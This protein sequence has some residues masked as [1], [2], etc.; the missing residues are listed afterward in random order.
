[1]A[2]RLTVL[3]VL[4]FAVFCALQ[5]QTKAFAVLFATHRFL[6]RALAHG[7]PGRHTLE[8]ARVP[9]VCQLFGLQDLGLV[10][11]LVVAARALAGSSALPAVGKALAVKFQASNFRALAA[12]VPVDLLGLF[13][14]AVLFHF[15]GGFSVGP[16]MFFI[17]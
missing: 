12:M 14:H 8:M 17:E 3:T 9:V 4:A 7:S 10:A 2:V 16:L 1:M 11:G 5:T 15:G 13:V 6:A